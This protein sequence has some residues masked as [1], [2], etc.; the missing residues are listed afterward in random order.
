VGHGRGGSGETFLLALLV[1]VQYLRDTGSKLHSGEYNPSLTELYD[2][3][4]VV[5]ASTASWFVQVYAPF[6]FHTGIPEIKTILGG[7]I[8]SGF[9]A[10]MVLLVKSLGLPLAVASGL[11]LGKVSP[12][13]RSAMMYN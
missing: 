6:A 11:S 12:E 7:Y 2:P 4:Q 8:I 1:P 13:A 3:S 5:F 9:F 10:P